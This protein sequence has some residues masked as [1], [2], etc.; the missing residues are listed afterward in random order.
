MAVLEIGLSAEAMEVETPI[1][2]G[3]RWGVFSDVGKCR[4]RNGD[5]EGPKTV[6][7]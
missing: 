5:F 7:V 4:E 2:A 1:I 3:L 6:C